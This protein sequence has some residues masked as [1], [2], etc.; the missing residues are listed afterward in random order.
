MLKMWQYLNLLKHLQ[1]PIF[2]WQYLIPPCTLT[3]KATF[4]TLDYYLLLSICKQT[5]NKKVFSNH[6]ELKELLSAASSIAIV[7]DEASDS[8]DK[9]CLHILFIP[10]MDTSKS[11]PVTYLADITYL[12][13][14]NAVTVSQAAL[15]CG[16][17]MGISYSN[18]S[19]CNQ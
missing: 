19:A 6:K 15:A 3:Y 14:V 7:T 17:T 11:N 10:G 8:H 1:K 18:V 2:P 12:E 4:Q 9:F 5:I 13:K 16:A